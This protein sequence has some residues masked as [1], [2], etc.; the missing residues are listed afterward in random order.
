MRNEACL[1]RLSCAAPVTNL[2][3]LPGSV[4]LCADRVGYLVT[5]RF[6]AT[7][8]FGGDSG[9]CC[10][11]SQ[12]YQPYNQDVLN[13]PLAALVLVK[14]LQQ[15]NYLHPMC[16][17]RWLPCYQRLRNHSRFWWRQRA[18]LQLQPNISALQPGY[19]QR[20]P[21]RPRPCEIAPTK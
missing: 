4:L 16:R 19:T 21:G 3:C 18:M 2:P 20:A 17:P 14:L 7:R 6:E 12:A 10:G 9:Q 11:Y 5:S 1:S 13:Q 15:S 8:D